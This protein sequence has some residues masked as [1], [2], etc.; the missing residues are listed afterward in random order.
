MDL[1]SLLLFQLVNGVIWGLIIALL[2]VGLNLVFGLLGVVNVAQGALYMLGA[3]ICWQVVRW[4]GSYAAGLIA[5]PLVAGPLAVLID[6]WFLKPIGHDHDLSIIMTIGLALVIEQTVFL[7][8]GADVRAVSA[9]IN[10]SLPLFGMS[11]PGLRVV[12][13]IVAVATLLSLALFLRF[14]QF[15]LWMRAVRFDP[16]VASSQGV[17]TQLVFAVTFGVSAALAAAGGAL[18]APIVNVRHDMGVD[19]IVVV[20]IVV[21]LGGLGNLFGS[22]IFAVLMASMEGVASTFISPPD[23]RLLVLCLLA[24][25]V[26][27]WPSGLPL[28]GIASR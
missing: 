26:V 21:I 5:A 1:S 3:M 2:A 23:A 17:P 4:T 18:A 10:W 27:I 16:D 28:R 19:V 20:F 8:Y 7:I 6:R 25:V 13:A 14:T 15:G 24:A 11:Y 12:I 9:P 22:A